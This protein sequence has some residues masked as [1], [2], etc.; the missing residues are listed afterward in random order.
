ME[1]HP[2]GTHERDEAC[3]AVVVL[4]DESQVFVQGEESHGVEVGEDVAFN[5]I[6]IVARDGLVIE[7]V[8]FGLVVF[9]DGHKHHGRVH[10]HLCPMGRPLQDVCGLESI[11]QVGGHRHTAFCRIWL[12]DDIVG[13]I[14]VCDGK[15]ERSLAHAYGHAG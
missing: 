7:D 13:M 2:H 11:A 3:V 10:E 14:S 1:I 4:D 8:V 6:A 9:L 12:V 15:D 5:G